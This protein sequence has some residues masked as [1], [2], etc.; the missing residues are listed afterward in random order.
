MNEQSVK[1]TEHPVAASNTIA[2]C[3]DPSTVSPGGIKIS[4]S[5][6]SS[7]SIMPGPR[8]DICTGI[9]REQMHQPVHYTP[10]IAN[11]SSAFKVTTSENVEDYNDLLAECE[12][13]GSPSNERLAEFRNE[14]RYRL[15]LAHEFHHSC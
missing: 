9:D 13:Y 7:T 10:S 2:P 8:T 5:P 11:D 6:A 3:Q 4:N 1:V 14:R 12:G 15:I